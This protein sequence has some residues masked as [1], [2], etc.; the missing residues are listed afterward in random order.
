MKW[1]VLFL[2]W[3]LQF[4]NTL[5]RINISVAGPVMMRS[6]HMTADRFGLVLAAFTFGYAVMQ[7]PGGWL[8]DRLGARALLA[9]SPLAWSIMTGLTGLAT[10]AAMLIGMRALFGVA[11]GASNGASFKLVGDWFAPAER[12]KANGLYLTALA[13]GPACVAPVAVWML[14]QVGWRGM[15]F[16]FSLPGLAMAVL[17]WLLLPAT[18]PRASAPADQG[19][20]SVIA[21]PR[22]WMLFAAYMAFN[23]AFW[24]FVGW[25]PSY[26]AISRHID[27][28]QLGI[29]ASVP[30]WFGFLGLLVAGGLGSRLHSHRALLVAGLYVLAAA[31]LTAT[32]TAATPAGSVAGLSAAACF[33]Y[34]GF[35][36]FWA[37]VLDQTPPDARGAFSGFINCGGQIGGFAAP[38]VVGG[39]VQLTGSFTGGFLFM[40]ASLAIGAGCFA[41]LH[42]AATRQAEPIRAETGGRG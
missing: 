16:W 15:F 40:I 36:P 37:I 23:V 8:A 14:G 4:V 24:G 35:G 32:F 27:L 11:E 21:R 5:D 19:L 33:L 31:A 7:I 13:L 1:R 26:L 42:V 17:M 29:T 38:I 22:S 6:L 9:A 39:I 20:G 2:I 28:K 12:S 10:S 3:L 25:M 30:Y 41:V 34:G 18:T